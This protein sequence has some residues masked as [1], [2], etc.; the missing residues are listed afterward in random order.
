M[1]PAYYDANYLLKLQISEFGSTQVRAHADTVLEIHTAIHSRAE[2]ASAAFRKVRE[3]VATLADY[4]RLLAQFHSDLADSVIVLLP[5]TDT[6]F[7]HIEAVF[8]SAPSG[9]FLRA[10]D[11]IQLATAAENGF[12]EIY[13]HDK[14]LLTAAPLFGLTGINVIPEPG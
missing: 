10:A 5:A 2:L 14:H 9:T 6:V 13:S 4:H 12:S 7:D 11:A 1:K 8:A 3:G